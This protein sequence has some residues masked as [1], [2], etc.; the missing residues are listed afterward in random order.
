M[1]DNAK[2]LTDYANIMPEEYAINVIMLD[3]SQKGLNY[4][5]NMLKIVSVK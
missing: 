5:R 3:L 4:A 1:L 2:N